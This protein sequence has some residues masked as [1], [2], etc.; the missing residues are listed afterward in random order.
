M[1]GPA[2]VPRTDIIRLLAEG[3][4]DREIGRRLH[5]STKRVGRIRTE[6]GAPRPTRT[7]PLTLTQKWATFTQP[8][9]GGH[10]AWTGY[11]REGTCPVLKHH[12]ENHTARKVAFQ[13]AAG[14]EPEGRVLAGCGWQPCVAPAHME[15]ARMR[16][17][18]AAIFGAAA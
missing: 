13:I 2:G 9:P 10:L 15:D 11:L 17:Q 18:Y 14:R 8:T 12:G 6:V 16:A 1:P 5:T 3:H 4:S 7:S